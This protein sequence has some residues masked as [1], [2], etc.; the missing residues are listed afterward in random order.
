MNFEI[1]KIPDVNNE[2]KYRGLER[3]MPK[4][5]PPLMKYYT[6]YAREA[7][8]AYLTNMK[9]AQT[10]IRKYQEYGFHFELV[11][12]SDDFLDDERFTFLGVDVASLGG[13]SMIKSGL[14]FWHDKLKPDELTAIINTLIQYFRPKLNDYLLFSEREDADLFAEVVNEISSIKLADKSE[15][16]YVEPGIL[17]YPKYL[18]LLK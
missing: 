5:V 16:G 17:Y 18:Y 9:K 2:L 15:Y 12:I 3:D 1:L 4:P 14:I 8:D 13:Y 10:L 6:W 7:G 11:R